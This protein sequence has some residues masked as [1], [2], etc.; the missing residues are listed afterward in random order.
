MMPSDSRTTPP[1]ICQIR[2]ARLRDA[3]LTLG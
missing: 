3:D 2:I 1:M